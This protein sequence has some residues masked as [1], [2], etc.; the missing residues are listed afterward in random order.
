MAT[1]AP[2][3][4]RPVDLDLPGRQAEYLRAVADAALEGRLNGADLRAMPADDA[5]SQV[6]KIL[7]LSP[8]A[9]DLVVI[10]GANAPDVVRHQERR[11]EAEGAER[12]GPDTT[13]TE[14]AD[15]W[16]PTAP[17]RR[18]TCRLLHEERTREIAG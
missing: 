2:S 1:T 9:A 3:R 15:G 12:Y 11:L 7:G 10:R 13:L 4:L 14:V 18:C 16:R 5:M 17:G 8:F 6:Q